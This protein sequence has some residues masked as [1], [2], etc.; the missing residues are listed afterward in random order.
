MKLVTIA[1]RFDSVHPPCLFTHMSSGFLPTQEAHKEGMFR[2]L[3]G[4]RNGLGA[5]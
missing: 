3:Y 4:G 5:M 1:L 2:T